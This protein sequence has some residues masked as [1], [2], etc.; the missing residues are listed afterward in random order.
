MYAFFEFKIKVRLRRS[1]WHGYQWC[2]RTEFTFQGF[3]SEFKFPL[4]LGYL[5]PALNNQ[6]FSIRA[7]GEGKNSRRR[8]DLQAL[9]VR[10]SFWKNFEICAF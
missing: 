6:G 4:N 10:M 7:G 5:N 1:A 9:K 3:I 2:V 8:R